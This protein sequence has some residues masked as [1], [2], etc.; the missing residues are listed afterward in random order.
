MRSIAKIKRRILHR[1]RIA[2]LRKSEEE[3]EFR[4]WLQARDRDYAKEKKKRQFA[5]RRGV[6]AVVG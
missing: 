6:P 4:D 2:I 3:I 5:N 1:F